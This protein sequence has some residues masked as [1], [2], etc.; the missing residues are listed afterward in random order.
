MKLVK[1]LDRIWLD[2][3]I[4]GS[5]TYELR[6]YDGDWQHVKEGDI[7]KF[8]PDEV[9]VK[10]VVVDVIRFD[11]LEEVLEKYGALLLPGKPEYQWAQVY[12]DIYGEELQ[13]RRLVL[14]EIKVIF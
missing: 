6:L 5:K 7:I 9:E 8:F 4:D 3:M 1:K 11:T 12:L 13:F 10:V 2:R 14:M